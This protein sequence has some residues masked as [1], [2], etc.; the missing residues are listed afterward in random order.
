MKNTIFA[1]LLGLVS[2]AAT[3]EPNWTIPRVA[4]AIPT[5]SPLGVA[6]LAVFFLLVATRVIKNRKHQ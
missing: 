1:I 4:E 3:A 6:G 2:G 5:L